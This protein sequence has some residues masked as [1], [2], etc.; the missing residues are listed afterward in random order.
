MARIVQFRMQRNPIERFNNANTHFLRFEFIQSK[1]D[2]FPALLNKSRQTTLA[3]I[4]LYL[5]GSYN[6]KRVAFSNR[7]TVP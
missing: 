5:M 1:R 7:T 2:S 6:I 4:N 3:L